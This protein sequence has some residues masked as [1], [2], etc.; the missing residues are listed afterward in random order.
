[1]LSPRIKSLL[2]RLLAAILAALA[3]ITLIAYASDYAVFR[4]RL[5]ANKAFGEVTVTT[6]DAVAQKSG[7]TQFIFN[8]P[9]IETCVH[10]LFPHAG[11]LPCWY[12]ER[13]T[14]QRTDI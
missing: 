9:H 10:T 5:R 1:V 8:P 7:K 14:E 4:Y 13:H 11:Y 12:L 2:K 3:S 6:Y